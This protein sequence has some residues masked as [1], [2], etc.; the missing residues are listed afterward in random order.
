M[1]EKKVIFWDIDTQFDFMTPQGKLQVPDAD[2]IID[3]ISQIRKFALENGFSVIASAD[4][5][6][7]TDEEISRTPDFENTFPQHCLASEPGSER[8]GFLGQLPIEY[9]AV[10]L[11]DTVGL[12]KLVDKEQFHVVIRKNKLDV[13]SNPNTVKLL[14]LIQPRTVVV[15]GVALDVCVRNTVSG[16]LQW[17]NAEIIVLKD[18]VKGLGI[19]PDE[20]ILK[21]FEQ[22][23]VK[24]AQL[25]DLRKG[26][27]N[28]VT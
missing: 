22:N 13:F 2:R 19:K 17:G 1:V 16:L 20:Q 12:K 15:F 25:N 3:K 4:W 8:V 10:E 18:G 21:E 23:G 24:I 26:I 9:V 7:P 28:V 5:H 11:V 14:E 27:L 6:R